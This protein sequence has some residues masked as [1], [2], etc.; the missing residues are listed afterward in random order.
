[1]DNMEKDTAEIEE[2]IAEETEITETTDETTAPC[3]KKKKFN[4][5]YLLVIMGI[6]VAGVL[7]YFTS[8][9]LII[10]AVN[11]NK[12]ITLRT[13]GRFDE[14]TAIFKEL[15]DY[16]DS[17]NQIKITAEE[18][19]IATVNSI[20]EQAESLFAKG[21]KIKAYELL[22]TATRKDMIK[23]YCEKYEE[24]ILND[25]KDD[26][27]TIKKKSGKIVYINK[28]KK[29]MDYSYGKPAFLI[30]CVE[31]TTEEKE[32]SFN[33]VLKIS[34]V[35]KKSTP[36]LPTEV[37]ITSGKDSYTIPIGY[38]E[39][40]C[41]YRSG[42][43]VENVEANISVA[44]VDGIRNVLKNGSGK[45]TLSGIPESTNAK[46]PTDL[47]KATLESV[48]FTKALYIIKAKDSVLNGQIK[49]KDGYIS[50]VHAMIECMDIISEKGVSQI[51]FDKFEDIYKTV[52]TMKNDEPEI[53]GQVVTVY[54]LFHH[55]Y[56]YSLNPYI[57]I[58]DSPYGMVNFMYIETY[59]TTYLSQS[60][61]ALNNLRSMVE[62]KQ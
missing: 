23:S 4:I 52:S 8:V 18:K 57:H 3:Q 42:A 14:A 6:L 22:N 36:I 51:L 54:N 12:A 28:S 46:I 10:P 34:F 62:D 61:P 2:Q 40:S 37:I 31:D 45:I 59:K 48:D 11:Y 60:M 56:E 30:Y 24:D 15:G 26:Y 13:E 21:Q 32:K 19:E 29:E 50:A 25:I 44:D 41:Y 7:I 17:K 58:G 5:K 16:K 38:Y 55:Y 1:M 9:N 20:I 39:R 27:A 53:A 43:W 47:V 35:N 33:I 49:E